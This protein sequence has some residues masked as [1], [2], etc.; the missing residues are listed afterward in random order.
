VSSEPGQVHR[1]AAT[2]ATT[3]RRKPSGKAAAPLSLLVRTGRPVLISE[4][5]LNEEGSAAIN[6][7]A[8]A[9]APVVFGV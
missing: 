7:C 4:Q 5:S 8:P 1:D 6:L 3:R 2:V 9:V